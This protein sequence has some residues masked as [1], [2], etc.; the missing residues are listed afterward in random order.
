MITDKLHEIT[1][2]PQQYLG[3]II[4]APKSVKIELTSVC[5]LKCEFCS[6]KDRIPPLKS[7]DMPWDLFV[8]IAN[9]LKNIG[10]EEIGLFLIGEPFMN[11]KL[12]WNAIDY[13]KNQLNIPY[14]F[15]TTNGVSAYKEKV[16]KCMELGLD[17]LKWSCNAANDEQFETLTGKNNKHYALQKENIKH[18]YE[19][20]LQ[21]NYSTKL[22]ASSIKFNDEQVT[23]MQPFLQ[24]FVLPYVDEHYWL[25]LYSMGGNATDRENTLGYTPIAGNSGRIGDSVNPI[26]CWSLF[27]AGHISYKGIA[28]AC[29]ADS[30]GNWTIGDLKVQNFMDAWNSVDMQLLRRAHLSGNII[31]TKCEYCAL[32]K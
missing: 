12:L 1:H 27:T 32:G 9:D 8:K 5:D 20:R 3:E 17:S 19:S 14:V 16:R 25:P 29:C 24:E 7:Q 13:L 22:Y 15:I 30:D 31:G 18:A 10:V 2:I 4:P 21:G 28:T 11:P 26:P 6:I 23:L